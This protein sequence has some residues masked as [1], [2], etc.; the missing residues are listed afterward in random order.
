MVKKNPVVFAGF[1]DAAGFKPF[2]KSLSEFAWRNRLVGL[3]SDGFLY[4]DTK[5]PRSGYYDFP[6]K[7]LP[8][9]DICQVRISS[10]ISL[11][12]I[13]IGAGMLFFGL[14]LGLVSLRDHGIAQLEFRVAKFILVFVVAGIV[15]IVGAR[16][17]VITAETEN[18]KYHWTSAP[19]AYRRTI[20]LC[21][22]TAEACKLNHVFYTSH[23]PST[24]ELP[25]L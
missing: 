18:R 9:K 23:V 20:P 22:A 25:Y 15:F 7:L 8:W 16:R 12:G 24:S 2:A 14:Y 11:V 4:V 6:P 21:A 13:I 17:N 3:T 5:V 19:L 1:E 10:T